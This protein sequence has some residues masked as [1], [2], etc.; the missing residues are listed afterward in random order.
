VRLWEA[1]QE[2]DI[3]LQF[4]LSKSVMIPNTVAPISAVLELFNVCDIS[5]P[6]FSSHH[7]CRI[8]FGGLHQA[9][10]LSFDQTP[11]FELSKVLLL[12]M[13]TI[14]PQR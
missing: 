13:T 11:L 2:F 6:L 12:C 9:K 4:S 8:K 5:P 14:K 10:G 3:Y 7:I 1:L